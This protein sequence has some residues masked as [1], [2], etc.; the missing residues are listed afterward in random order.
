MVM[1]ISNYQHFD[2]L[3]CWKQC[4]KKQK[5]QAYDQEQ[6]LFMFENLV[7]WIFRNDM[8][9]KIVKMS[10]MIPFE[11]QWRT[12]LI[13][14]K[15]LRVGIYRWAIGVNNLLQKM[16]YVVEIQALCQKQETFELIRLEV[17]TLNIWMWASFSFYKF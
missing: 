2:R 13:K 11:A 6:C 4:S 9:R 17:D 16:R 3:H 14:R 12:A 10:V 1:L 5:E 7:I 8:L 15:A